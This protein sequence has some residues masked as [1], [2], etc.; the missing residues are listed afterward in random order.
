MIALNLNTNPARRALSPDPRTMAR[1]AGRARRPASTPLYRWL[2]LLA[3]LVGL[4]AISYVAETAQA[5]QASYQI[6]QLKA[7]QERLLNDQ[8]QT[9]YDIAAHSSAVQWDGDAARLGLARSSQWQ[10]VPASQ[11]PVAL[12]RPEPA[13]PASAGESFFDR[14]AVALGRP[15]EAQARGR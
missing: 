1:P 13:A 11:A 4:F 14:L 12:A 6:S 10:Y 9:R 15:A 5:T 3:V 8:R 7:Q 2:A